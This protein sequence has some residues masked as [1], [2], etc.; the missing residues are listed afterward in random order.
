MT[1]SAASRTFH[2]EVWRDINLHEDKVTSNP[3]P[4]YL[5]KKLSQMLIISRTKVIYIWFLGI[6]IAEIASGEGDY[7]VL[8][9]FLA[10][11]C[12]QAVKAVLSCRGPGEKTL[13]PALYTVLKQG[14]LS[15]STGAD[16]QP[17]HFI[18][19]KDEDTVPADIV[20]LASGRADHC[21]LLDISPYVGTTRIQ[22]KSVVRET[23]RIV[24]SKEL[25]E[26]Y[27]RVA[28]LQG[29]VKV[30][31][32][33]LR[34][35][36]FRGLVKLKGYPVAARLSPDNLMLKGSRVVTTPWVL[37][38]VAYTG[39]D[40]KCELLSHSAP[41]LKRAPTN[42]AV[43]NLCLVLIVAILALTLHSYLLE[44]YDPKIQFDSTKMYWHYILIYGQ[45]I[46]ATFYL[47]IEA[48]RAIQ[49]YLLVQSAD[50]VTLP[51]QNSHAIDTLGAID[52]VFLDK[53]GTITLNSL[54]AKCALVNL[55]DFCRCDLPEELHCHICLDRSYKSTEPVT[56]SN[57]RILH[58]EATEHSMQDQNC[59][60]AELGG[61][62]RAK[63]SV[64]YSF[65]EALVLCNSVT[66]SAAGEICSSSKYDQALYRM[67]VNLGIN[68]IEKS[69]S[70][71]KFQLGG[72]II[73]FTTIAV[74]DFKPQ[75]QRMRVLVQREG[76]SNGFIFIKGTPDVF[77]QLLCCSP[78]E[79]KKVQNYL[80]E[81]T[82]K[83][84]K[85]V[86]Y[87]GK[88]LNPEEME[89]T[90]DALEAAKTSSSQH[91]KEENLF[92]ELEKNCVLLAIVGLEDPL[93]D[94]IPEAVSELN[95]AGIRVWML[96]GDS[97]EATT[98][99]ALG[100]GL[101]YD[102]TSVVQLRN[103]SL[104]S[105]CKAELTQQIRTKILGEPMSYNVSRAE[106]FQSEE[107]Y[108]PWESP[109]TARDTFRSAASHVVIMQRLTGIHHRA[110]GSLEG[111]QSANIVD[112]TVLIDGTSFSTA[113]REPDTRELLAVLLM[114]AS[115]VAGCAMY[116]HQKAL[117]VRFVKENFSSNP[118]TLAIG[119]A[120]NDIPMLQSAEIGLN[121]ESLASPAVSAASELTISSPAQLPS[122][123]AAGFFMRKRLVE[124]VADWVY[125]VI[126]PVGLVWWYSY[127]SHYSG[128]EVGRPTLWT[129][130]AVQTFSVVLIKSVFGA[131]R[132]A[133]SLCDLR[134][135]YPR[136]NS[137]FR[138]LLKTVGMALI[139]SA[140]I[141]SCIY[142]AARGKFVPFPESFDALHGAAYLAACW[143]VLLHLLLTASQ[144][145]AFLIYSTL[146]FMGISVY[147]V[148]QLY[149]ESSD[150]SA[151]RQM[152]TSPAL[153]LGEIAA[154]STSLLFTFISSTCAALFLSF[155][156]FPRQ[157]TKVYPIS[158]HSTRS[159][160]IE[161]LSKLYRDSTFWLR[162]Q[163]NFGYEM[164]HVWLTFNSAQIEQEFIQI[165]AGFTKR[166][167]QI[168]IFTVFLLVYLAYVSS[169]L[170]YLKSRILLYVLTSA[171]TL[172][173]A[174]LPPSQLPTFLVLTLITAGKFA[175]E[176]YSQKLDASSYIFPALSSFA[177]V[178][179]WKLHA[180]LQIWSLITVIIVISLY[181]K[182]DTTTERGFHIAET[183]VIS[184]LY[185]SSLVLLVY[186]TESARRKEFRKLK[187]TENELERSK[188]V[189][190]CLF[191][192]F[193]K[194]AVVL[195]RLPI[196]MEESL[197]TVL[198][199]DICDFDLICSLHS[200][201]GLTALLDDLWKKLD[202]IC[203]SHG[204]AKVETVGKTF[205]ACAGLI[206]QENELPEELAL[207]SPARRAVNMALE[208]Q[209][210]FQFMSLKHGPLQANIG[211][212]S[213][214]VIAGVV[215]FHKPQFALIGDTINTASRMSSTAP[216]PCSIQ[217]TQSTYEQLG[218]FTQGLALE[219]RT[220][221]V[222]GKGQMVT[223]LVKDIEE[224]RSGRRN[225]TLFTCSLN[226][227]M[228]PAAPKAVE[229][230]SGLL[231]K[232]GY[233]SFAQLF[234]RKDTEVVQDVRW[235]ISPKEDTPK[236][237][238]FH[239][240]TLEK[241]FKLFGFGLVLLTAAYNIQNAL[242]IAE[243]IVIQQSTPY[244]TLCI[245]SGCSIGLL[246]TVRWFRAWRGYPLLSLLGYFAL[247]V[248]SSWSFDVSE[249]G[250]D[251]SLTALLVF[252]LVYSLSFGL[253]AFRHGLLLVSLSVLYWVA[254]L[255]SEKSSYIRAGIGLSL[256]PIVLM[257]LSYIYSRDLH[258]RIYAN[259]EQAAAK[260]IG[261]TERLLMQMM[262]VHV[263][264]SLLQEER[265]TDELQGVT[266]LF[267]DIVGFTELSAHRSPSEI[268]N[269][270]SSLFT[271]FDRLCVKNKVYKVHTIGDCYVAMGYT[272]SK[273][274]RDFEEECLNIT[275]QAC[276]MIAV[277]RD[278][279]A[280]TPEI[281]L[282]MR[283]GIH[284]ATGVITA[285]ITGA[286]IVRYD[287][288]GPDVLVANKMESN[289]TPGRILVSDVTK[290]T[291]ESIS[292]GLYSFTE[293]GP[294]AIP[295]LGRT[296][297]GFFIEQVA[298]AGS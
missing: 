236:Q 15:S 16:L 278:I 4:S 62:M 207:I 296:H 157:S 125:A 258:L 230:K 76:C 270:L 218:F 219:S 253:L 245:N 214:P 282:D 196:V 86:I 148:F 184:A 12:V 265:I 131:D 191:P 235:F 165:S 75:T 198:F 166:K 52:Y 221:T 154:I 248:S 209:H 132:R 128:T 160:H 108:T 240:Q 138:T 26:A 2:Q 71:C 41:L 197:V 105:D 242:W 223:F 251:L 188:D 18:C 179:S 185:Y 119:D 262:P 286:K 169:A 40:C 97:E 177:F 69:R 162:Q 264:E 156:P 114:C 259:L 81:L 140:I 120:E 130:Y 113:L 104:E 194:E 212:C 102:R 152:F 70:G 244:W 266:L 190:S 106:S 117:L 211:I 129:L 233:W 225:S 199:I 134:L 101:F 297:T 163:D 123:L 153:L 277:I 124:A 168:V 249:P 17:G 145:P 239:L 80:S 29:T 79:L 281:E 285:G 195:G 115:A 30:S 45:A 109:P 67:T 186:L 222:K 260:E 210:T 90:I 28:K 73:R 55:V 44:L 206:E 252:L 8:I 172:V 178:L 292:P 228:S 274:G 42:V 74:T 289:G 122:L 1:Q 147:S 171:V 46:P 246:L 72:E 57:R 243:M 263:Y 14:E 175:M 280:E 59:A 36:V 37:G 215:G 95:Q 159:K 204:L 19:L 200:P 100:V 142:L 11:I 257:S 193:V 294:I 66:M 89:A 99:T 283:I 25:E 94:D 77:N 87:A 181:E 83:H 224:V 58:F 82:S 98:S 139:H 192:S 121:I 56:Q 232:L 250:H 208:V 126:V 65:C 60:F 155:S 51:L 173:L 261:R 78:D 279:N 137:L 202:D 32:P 272:G 238:E 237:R 164:H 21:C 284:T 110:R 267:A 7:R 268:V 276:D 247:L 23:Q 217:I 133:A 180:L 111:E 201:K 161:T 85:S 13:N 49:A 269:L 291:L 288:F 203:D 103:L 241:H 136:R 135:L 53:T 220:L 174:W 205:L 141:Y 5:R 293:K 167:Q 254:S 182:A 229:V 271:R 298:N 231:A 189:L 96:S 27:S 68:I 48:I 234:T 112:Y 176:L 9:P 187:L 118:I 146:V 226:I 24:K 216:A 151:F 10:L 84:Y 63:S 43:A 92:K 116:P 6:S 273:L 183:L 213:G 256:L 3:E 150:E 227:T 35:D 38:L 54:Q 275:S 50:S 61:L 91:R 143:T 290:S 20:L 255:A 88:E 158:S 170:D 93:R 64:A 22:S 295:S 39:K 33:S 31:H 149:S 287:I 47:L 107:G 34:V 144:F 127:V